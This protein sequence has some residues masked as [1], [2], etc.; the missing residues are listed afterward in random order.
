[1]SEPW[2]CIIDVKITASA[3]DKYLR[4]K[5]KNTDIEKYFLSNKFQKFDNVLIQKNINTSKSIAYFYASLLYDLKNSD[6]DSDVILFNYDANKQRVFIAVIFDQDIFPTYEKIMLSMLSQLAS[7]KDIESNDTALFISPWT[8]DFYSAYHLDKNT[9]HKI[10]EFEVSQTIIDEYIE[11]F[12]SFMEKEFFPPIGKALRKKNYYY[13]PIR[14]AFNRYC[15]EQEEIIRPYK[16]SQATKDNPLPL[17]GH[18]Y[19]FNNK[20]YE[21]KKDDDYMELVGA[22]PVTLREVSML[23]DLFADKNHVYLGY[24]GWNYQRIEGID[25]STFTKCGTGEPIYWKD[26]NY[27]YLDRVTEEKTLIRLDNVDVKS[28]ITTNE[29]GFAKDKNHIYFQGEILPL[30]VKLARLTM[31]G[32]AFDDNVV[33]YYSHPVA[34]DGKTFKVL[35]YQSLFSGPFI[36]SDKNGLYHY[37]TDS[38]RNTLTKLQNLSPDDLAK[39]AQ[40]KMYEIDF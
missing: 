35:R 17:L 31:Y 3:L 25:G 30:N 20:V 11:N 21:K 19:T 37:D 8:R 15:K 16:I 4:S 27:V 26:K 40:F 29:F 39:I 24:Y 2:G 28:F 9:L 36:V 34:L 6:P 5:Q 13:K 12:F 10:D 1:M 14:N 23:S 7:Y 38:N 33:Y 18:F 22:D 32:F